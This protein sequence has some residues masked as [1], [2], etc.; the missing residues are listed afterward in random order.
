MST[1]LARGPV[2][3]WTENRVSGPPTTWS[4]PLWWYETK[5]GTN[6][7][8]WQ[9]IIAS[10][11]DAT[12]NYTVDRAVVARAVPLSMG[13]RLMAKEPPVWWNGK[14]C[15]IHGFPIGNYLPMPATGVST[16]N[17]VARATA[18]HNNKLIELMAPFKGMTFVG[19]LRSTLR[20]V[21]GRL[22]SL[23]G[24][25]RKYQDDVRR[26]V[27]RSG[28]PD[29]V[30]LNDISGLYLEATYGW[31]PLFKEL[32]SL[33][34]SLKTMDSKFKT[35]R[36]FG[37]DKA[38]VAPTSYNLSWGNDLLGS[39]R[40]TYQAYT[41]TSALH[42]SHVNLDLICPPEVYHTSWSTYGFRLSE[43][44]PT[45]WELTPYS[46]L[47]DYFQNG[48]DVVNGLFLE[49]KAARYSFLNTKVKAAKRWRFT[50]LPYTTSNYYSYPSPSGS[51]SG[52]LELIGERF[53]R[54]KNP[55][56]VPPFTYGLPRFGSKPWLNM[57][58][59]LA[60]NTTK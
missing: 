30:I 1:V 19:E 12:S 36:G 3:T 33:V 38:V 49:T 11:G 23:H 41:V 24:G 9:Q 35:I 18:F 48:M 43:F 25:V 5:S 10:G 45:L 60:N 51:S 15:S 27:R 17:A 6:Q 55:S 26:R 57:A 4:Y 40:R 28:R 16:A 53:T 22:S 2:L 46:F 42:V 37:E 54:T 47:L 52:G 21:K 59:L 32:E 14:Y 13:Y 44:I 7:P 58:A 34:G 8:N 56:T 29:R 20:M 50:P 39:F 31:T